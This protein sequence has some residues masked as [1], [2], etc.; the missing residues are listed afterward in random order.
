M[1][2]SNRKFN[3]D[4]DA[5]KRF[6]DNYVTMWLTSAVNWSAA[7]KKQARANLGLGNG[8]ID[9]EPTPDSDNI[10]KSGGIANMYGS[11]T[12]DPEYAYVQTDNE[13]K[14]LFGVKQDGSMY[15][16]EGCPTQVKDY[17][18]KRIADLSLDE[19]EDIV[20]FLA[21]LEKGDAT[22]QDLLDKKVDGE[23]VEN[24]EYIEVKTD[25]EDKILEATEKDGSKVIGS[26]KVLGKM[27][28][29]GVSYKV[30]ENPEYLAAWVDAEDKVVF[31]FNK[32]GKTF[33]GDASFLDAIKDLQNSFY[34]LKDIISEAECF[35]YMS[36]ETDSENKILGGRKPD[37]TKFENLP[38]EFKDEM[39][40][41]GNI[42][43]NIQDSEGRIKIETD[44]EDKVLSYR[45]SKGILHEEAG[46]KTPVIETESLN[47]PENAR[48]QVANICNERI[49]E[50]NAKTKNYN[51]PKF[52]YVNIISETFYLTKNEGYSDIN[53][54]YLIRD[55]EDTEVNAK[56]QITLDYFYV[57]S[58][59][60]DNG[61]GT[62]SKYNDGV[63]GHDV[64]L[65]FYPAGL[66]TK[67]GYNFYVTSS[68]EDGQIVPTSIEVTQITDTPRINAWPVNKKDEHYCIAEI[69][70]DHYL[71]GTFYV[72]VKFQ[73]SST[74]GCRKRNFRVTFYKNTPKPYYPIDDD[75]FGKKNKIKIGEFVRLSG[76]NL[77][78]NW[79]D[80]TRIKEI[81]MYRLIEAVW[82]NTGSSEHYPWAKQHTAYTGATGIIKGFPIECS[83]NGDF[84]G[85]D[86]FGLKKDGK[87]YILDK[88][89]DGMFECGTR[90]NYQD[91][92]NWTDAHPGDWEDE[93]NDEEDWVIEHQTQSNYDAL[94][95]FF[96]FINGNLTEHG[97]IVPF[98]KSTMPDRMSIEHW[99][100]Y[101]ICLQVFLMKDN[102][103]RNMVLYTGSDKKKFYPFF[104]DLD[105]SWNFD[106]TT[107]NLDIMVPAGDT[108]GSGVSYAADMSLWENFKNEWWDEII[109]CYHEL[110]ESVL[111]TT[112]MKKVA[113]DIIYSIPQE[114]VES[115][116]NKW[117]ALI[118]PSEM[119]YLIN[120]MEKR[121]RWLDEDY[122]K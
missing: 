77:K 101:I 34:W 40:I 52:G 23:Y 75:K 118:Y 56:A 53:G 35:E 69:D 94:T 90:G 92:T 49:A 2:Y 60:I 115:E 89:E 91:K 74:L 17:I 29:S 119:L 82:N 120:L 21:D 36:V 106:S 27:E 73:G 1:A 38:M 66:V 39:S 65:I 111:N 7:K 76:F 122:Y 113:D 116:R 32:D 110:R 55:Y 50:N 18:E 51:L 24:P 80:Y 19:Y 11:Y 98:D 71:S 108:P 37:G 93:L 41:N 3:W 109:N 25:A 22:L 99:I 48:E 63:E 46:I 28:V 103:C 31:G 107:Y 67:V 44:V 64:K 15:F 20:A 117:D 13:D 58:S 85:L 102:T 72:G 121:L 30:I 97:D 26:L 96:A 9:D 5:L 45:D 112:F 88:D 14:I 42:M 79:S 83:I 100:K 95:E 114:V 86:V 78:A 62:Y 104:Y 105:L 10:A 70:F 12:E 8:D 16:G 57:K 59:L 33:V 6:R 84:Y 87:N 81:V 54:I 47:L 43:K 61:D 68:L 4:F